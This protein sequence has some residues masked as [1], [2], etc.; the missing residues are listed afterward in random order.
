M[1]VYVCALYTLVFPRYLNIHTHTPQFV[2][3]SLGSIAVTLVAVLELLSSVTGTMIAWTTQTRP[4]AV[5]G[6]SSALCTLHSVL[7]TLHRHCLE[8]SYKLFHSYNYDLFIMSLKILSSLVLSSPCLSLY[9]EY[10]LTDPLT[11]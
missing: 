6:Y 11:V 8:T 10:S 2:P 9:Y 7:C 4:T 5:S 1:H 3:V